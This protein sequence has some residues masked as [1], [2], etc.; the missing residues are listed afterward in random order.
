MD[1]DIVNIKYY[2]GLIN[3]AKL[4]INTLNEKKLDYEKILIKEKIE[5][6]KKSGF[7]K[8]N[9]KLKSF[10][11]E[12]EN[13]INDL[14]NDIDRKNNDITKYRNELIEHEI[15]KVNLNILDDMVNNKAKI[16]KDLELFRATFFE[17]EKIVK[18]AIELYN[19]GHRISDVNYVVKAHNTFFYFIEHGFESP[20]YLYLKDKISNYNELSSFLKNIEALR[21]K[22]ESILEEFENKKRTIEKNSKRKL[23]S[24][25]ITKDLLIYYIEFNEILMLIQTNMTEEINNKENEIKELLKNKELLIKKNE[26]EFIYMLREKYNLD[27]F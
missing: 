12:I 9:S 22:L 18:Q 21:L 3:Q 1:K 4:E 25:A 24:Y 23:S 15:E 16:K 27:I 26:N 19:Q 10:I 11:K 5:L 14:S 7:F 6:S 20:N 8:F 2:V 13:T 17:N